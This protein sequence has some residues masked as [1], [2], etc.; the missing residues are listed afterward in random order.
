MSKKILSINPGATSTK[1][2]IF[3]DSKPL[4]EEKITH[5][6]E[7][8]KGF[9]N[10]LDQYEFRSQLIRDFIAEKRVPLT[11]LSAV[12]AR[13]GPFKSL[14]GGTYGVNDALMRDIKEGNVQADHISNIGALLANEIAKP[15]NIPA[16]IVDPVSVDELEE[17]ARVSGLPEL[18]RKSL[19]HTLNIKMVGKNYG[20]EV[21]TPY[22][23]LNLIINHLGTGI[24]ITAHKQGRMIDVNNANDEGPFSPQRV[25]TLPTTGLMKLCYSGEYSAAEM[26]KKLL[27]AGGVKAYLGTDDMLKVKAMIEDGDEKA[28]LII[29]A[30]AYQVAK[31]TGAMATVLKGNID[32]ILIT[33]SLA[34]FERLVEQVEDRI[35]FIAPVKIYPGED[36]LEALALGALRVLNGEE[37]IKIYI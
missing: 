13:G 30:M 22:E 14:K 33:G 26:K 28:K 19:A 20:R 29:E 35:G 11:E 10:Y 12:V 8:L 36:E 3:E 1:I 18:T 25:G 31:E 6:D 32:A 17:V 16:Y 15:L 21:G 7:D 4:F 23:K 37:K 2:G 27:K 24:S 34:Y 9:G 5:H